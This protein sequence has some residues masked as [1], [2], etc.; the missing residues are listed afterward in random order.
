MALLRNRIYQI[1]NSNIYWKLTNTVSILH[2]RNY[3]DT[4]HIKFEPV[5]HFPN[6][7]LIS[8]LNSIK[9]L[10]YYV[11]GVSI[12]IAGCLELLQV[13][14]S[15]IT[16]GVGFVGFTVCGIFTTVSF[17]TRNTIGFI[18]LNQDNTLVKIS[19]VDGWG[20]RI[21]VITKV[22]DWVPLNNLPHSNLDMIYLRPLLESQN[23]RLKFFHKWGVY[24]D[25]KR[26]GL[27]LE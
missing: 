19:Y 7:R 13:L 17:M 11:T 16:L 23:K 6:I 24:L 8:T 22:S 4:K 1:L 12:P 15:Q 14:P 27:A 26:F 9:K 10:Q 25:E 2:N 3:A 5:Y 18:Y 21:N 20:K